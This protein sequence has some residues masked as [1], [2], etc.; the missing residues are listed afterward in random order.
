MTEFELIED[1][2]GERKL[3]EKTIQAYGNDPEQNYG[4]FLSH[5]T[6]VDKCVF[7]HQDG[8]GILTTFDPKTKDWIMI[9]TPIA[10]KTEQ[11]PF[12]IDTLDFL[13]KKG[14]LIK[15]VAEFSSSG[16]KEVIT[17][18]ENKYV[19]HKPSSIL[20]WPVYDMDTWTGT[21]LRG[22]EWKKLRNLINQMNKAHKLE[23]VDSKSVDKQQLNEIINKWVKLRN[24]NGFGIN[25]K[26]SNRADDDQYK[27]LVELD[28]LG[29]K[30]A[31][32]V[33]VDGKA[34]SITAGWEIPNENGAY[35]S[36]IGIYDLGIE[37]LGVY[38]NWKDLVML[39]NAGYKKVDF[40][41]SPKPLL[42]FKQ[43]FK[44]SSIYTT[45]IFSITK[46]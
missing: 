36:G 44:P 2:E 11:I 20:Y 10:P 45:F 33:L 28:F 5:E 8:Y 46:K 29:C 32:T 16:R 1:V 37:S 42:Q 43:K 9:S 7:I 39:K 21:E 35:Y 24:Q 17:A 27:K 34:A 22:G 4:Y 23:I 13:S 19:V 12:L 18:A 3:I 25:R 6:D 14:K 15:Y 30:Y 40:G 41:G 26:D 31:K 38:V